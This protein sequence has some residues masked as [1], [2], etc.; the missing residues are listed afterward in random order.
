MDSKQYKEAAAER[1]LLRQSS[2]ISFG[3]GAMRE[4]I[5]YDRIEFEKCA[6]GE[7]YNT[8]F[9][10]RDELVTQ[11]LALCQ[12]YNQTPAGD[13][14]R[15]EALIRELFGKVGKNPDIEPNVFCGFGF[16]IEVGDNFF[17]NNGCN[18][19]DPAKITFGDN[20]F[21][22]P[23]C[24]FYTAHHP[25][26]YKLRNRLYEWAFPITVGDN[27]WFGGGCRILPGVTIGSNVV[28]GAG[29]VVTRD[30]PDNCIAAGNPC[31]ILRYIDEDGREVKKEDGKEQAME[32]GKK[33][34]IFAD[35]DLP[36][37]GD[38]E[39][40][41]HEALS[42]V[43]CGGEDAE[44]QVKV[45]FSDREPDRF[46]L[47]VPADRV[48]CFRLDG[49]VGESEYQIP[50]GQYALLLESNVPIVAVLGRLDRRENVSYYELDG[51]SC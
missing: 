4:A 32:Y 9:R 17:A 39:P 36:P 50:F 46:V 15:R 18:F 31:R 23:D 7:M 43:N 19:M 37:R 47:R 29:S 11:A 22:G 6:R 1:K 38:S 41:G 34:W 10:G 28:I 8:A 48:I 51:Y 13:K 16:N 20:V 27:V 25:I 44:I 40:Y 26:G 21:I 12:E 35:G 5:D 49:A 45:L 30:I 33:T 3:G 42:I 14:K 2:L 24:G